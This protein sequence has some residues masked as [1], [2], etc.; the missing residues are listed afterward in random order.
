M[1]MRQKVGLLKEKLRQRVQDRLTFPLWIGAWTT[2]QRTIWPVTFASNG[3]I[4]A[5]KHA[6]VKRKK[7]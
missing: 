5:V 3:Q 2:I 6:I 7:S 4:G 1:T